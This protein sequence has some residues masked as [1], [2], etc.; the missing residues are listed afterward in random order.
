MRIA[1]FTVALILAASCSHRQPLPVA[2]KA[3]VPPPSVA[4]LDDATREF[5]SADYGAAARDFQQY[6]NLVPSGGQRDQEPVPRDVRVD[7][8]LCYSSTGLQ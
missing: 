5:S 2:A 3:P 6:L 4:A 1:F 8:G 7:G